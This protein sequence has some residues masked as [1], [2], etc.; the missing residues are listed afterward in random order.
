MEYAYTEKRERV[1]ASN[2]D[3]AKEYTCPICDGK[4]IPKQGNCNIHHFAHVSKCTDP[5]Y[6]D[7]SK[8]HSDWQAQF[9]QKNR[10]VVIEYNNEKH[11][12]D[13]MACGYI[14]EFQHSSITSEEFDERNE[15]YLKYGKKVIWIFDFVDEY[16]YDKMECYD[17]WC[18]KNDNGGKYRWRYPKRFLKNY[19]PQ[20]DK[21][22]IV[23]F[24]IAEEEHNNNEECYIEKVIWAIE[25]YGESNFRRFSTS[26]CPSNAIELIEYIKKGML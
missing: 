9:P 11:R 6:Y 14:V 1:H 25:E 3:K 8:W 15:F 2:A 26:Y 10:E 22:I 24:Q 16:K 18:G 13:V 7:M 17:E 12:A 20:R 19:I 4:V 21:N 5:W 23:F